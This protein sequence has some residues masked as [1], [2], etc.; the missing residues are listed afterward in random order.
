M[1]SFLTMSTVEDVVRD[2][3]ERLAQVARVVAP[4][5]LRIALAL[6]FF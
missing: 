4:P 6:P 2:L 3:V 5:V 1:S